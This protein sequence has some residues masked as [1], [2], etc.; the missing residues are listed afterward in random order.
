MLLQS[1]LLYIH[2]LLFVFWIGTDVGVFVLG[3]IAQKAE[4]HPQRRV[5][6]FKT[7][8]TLDKAPRVCFAL[9]VP[10]GLQLASVSGYFP[11]TLLQLLLVWLVGAVWLI[12]VVG[13]FFLSVGPVLHAMRYTDRAIQGLVCLSLLWLGLASLVTGGPV[14]P[15]FLAWKIVI[16]GVLAGAALVLDFLSTPVLFL[17]LELEENGPSDGLQTQIDRGMNRIYVFVGIIY[18]TALVSAFLGVS[19]LPH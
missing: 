18:L 9:M 13:S 12:C 17:F 11:L 7:A 15:D 1:I 5:D 16:F 10:V 6:S 14:V 19:K 2:I 3:K 8:L 4:N